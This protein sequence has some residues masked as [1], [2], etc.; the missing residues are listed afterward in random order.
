[1]SLAKY[2][3]QLALVVVVTCLV[4]PLIA[5]ILALSII[6]L[7][8]VSFF[9]FSCYAFYRTTRTRKGKKPMK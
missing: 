8:Y 4:M 6:P 9:L 2:A 5:P 7:G 3:I 1:M